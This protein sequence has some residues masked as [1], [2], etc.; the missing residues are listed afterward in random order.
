MFIVAGLSLFVVITIITLLLIAFLL[1]QLFLCT[2]KTPCLG[3][4][5]PSLWVLLILIRMVIMTP[6]EGNTLTA[7]GYVWLFFISNIPAYAA[8]LVYWIV[9]EIQKFIRR[10]KEKTQSPISQNS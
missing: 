7:G 6:S 10:R 2:R 5:L 4:I 8:L 1:F 3:F 9:F